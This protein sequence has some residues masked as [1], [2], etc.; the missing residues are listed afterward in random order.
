MKLDKLGVHQAHC[1]AL[2]L[3]KYVDDDCPV[4]LRLVRQEYTCGYCARDGIENVNQVFDVL[5]GELE[6]CKHC[7]HV[8]D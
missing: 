6:T 2:H 7:G 1:C 3:C 8:L 5:S 4:V